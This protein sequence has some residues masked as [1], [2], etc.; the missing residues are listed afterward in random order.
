MSAKLITFIYLLSLSAFAR[1]V[2]LTPFQQNIKNCFKF[3]MDIQKVQNLN[4]LYDLLDKHYP[5][6]TNETI[7]REVLYKEKGEFKKL[8]FEK[9][10]ISLYKVM[11]DDSVKLINND[12]RQKGLT[13]DSSINQLL[14][15]SEIRSDWVKVKE[16]RSEQTLLY[17]GRESGQFKSITFEKVG[18]KFKLECSNKES[19]DICICHL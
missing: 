4:Q 15:R 11:D 2:K 7:Y 5:L 1:E 19:S 10:Q 9:G 8:K 3:E 14:L 18:E 13:D 16:V 12:V 17:F 6:K